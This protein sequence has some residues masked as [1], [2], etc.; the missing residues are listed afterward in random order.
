M[1]EALI[2]FIADYTTS[3][4]NIIHFLTV[5]L[6]NEMKWWVT[7][8]EILMFLLLNPIAPAINCFLW[9]VFRIIGKIKMINYF[10]FLSKLT[11]LINGT[12]ESP[13]QIIL[14][15]FFFITGRIQPP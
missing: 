9:M 12:F 11:C 13:V 7:A 10:K 5:S 4:L 8:P 3:I 6:Q 2:V 15:L 1:E 14:L